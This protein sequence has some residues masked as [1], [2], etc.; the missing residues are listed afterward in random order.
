MGAVGANGSD[1]PHHHFH[2]F[3]ET[4]VT[5]RFFGTDYDSLG[6]PKPSK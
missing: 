1:A 2:K 5:A 6:F 4:S 3:K